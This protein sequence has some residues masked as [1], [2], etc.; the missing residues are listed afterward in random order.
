MRMR[1]TCAA[2]VAGLVLAGCASMPE[3]RPEPPDGKVAVTDQQAARVFDRYD[4]VNNAAN[5]ELDAEAIATV[6]ADPLLETS[7]TGF[8]LAE[9]G[10]D[11]PAEPYYHTDVVG[12]S[13]RFDGY[14][15]WFVATA[16]INDDPGRITVHSLSRE[17]ANGEWI[18]EQAANLG[19]VD[20]PPI[21]LVDG[22]TPA[23]TG[24]QVSGVTAALEQAYAYL[25]GGDAPDGV[26]VTAEGLASYRTWAEEST[27][28]LDEVTEPEIS[29][30]TDGRAEVRV[31]PAEDGVL[32]LATARCILRQSVQEDVPGDM[33]LGGELSVLAPES[34][35]TVE[36]VSSHPL[37]VVVPDT[38]DAEVF[39][40]GWR[41]SEVT[42]LAD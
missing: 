26:D 16:R 28:Q 17:S 5:A 13:P 4:G 22:E 24:D 11:A 35:R 30:Q 36:F 42:M 41:W 18:M 31:L 25:A 27:I 12:Y 34:G 37:V 23:A 9:A 33:T 29:C 21:R 3:S 1:A 14:P 32:G 19:D 10:E 39:S 2:I 20:L 40:G 7:V 38:G 6:E 15:L 8:L